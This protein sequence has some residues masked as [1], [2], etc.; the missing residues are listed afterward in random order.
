MSLFNMLINKGVKQGDES[1]N[2]S[3][4]KKNINTVYYFSLCFCVFS[5]YKSVEL[6]SCMGKFLMFTF[7][8]DLKP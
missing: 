8:C 5:F 7:G 1:R 4:P 3:N 6:I 2:K